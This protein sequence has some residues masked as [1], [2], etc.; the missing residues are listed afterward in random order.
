MACLFECKQ[1]FGPFFW[2]IQLVMLMIVGT[3]T[4][5]FGD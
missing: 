3:L 4:L 1:N 2:G 5:G